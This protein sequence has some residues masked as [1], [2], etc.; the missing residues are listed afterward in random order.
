MF[1]FCDNLNENNVRGR[2]IAGGSGIE[3]I[4]ER[5]DPRISCGVRGRLARLVKFGGAQEIKTA[6]GVEREVREP[7][8]VDED[9]V[10][11]PEG[12]GGEV[13]G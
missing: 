8:G 9:V 6:A 4:V 1:L 11:I 10:G 12:D 13:F 2:L 5:C 7:R 3:T